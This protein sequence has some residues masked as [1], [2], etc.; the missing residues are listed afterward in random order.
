MSECDFNAHPAEPVGLSKPEFEGPP[1]RDQAPQ[2]RKAAALWDDSVL[3]GRVHLAN[4]SSWPAG[5]TWIVAEPL[6][7][8]A[9]RTECLEAAVENIGPPSAKADA[10]GADE[11]RSAGVGDGASPAPADPRIA[12]AKSRSLPPRR[13]AAGWTEPDH[14]QRANGCR[15]G[16]RARRRTGRWRRRGR[17]GRRGPPP[18]RLQVG[19]SAKVAPISSGSANPL[20]GRHRSSRGA[21]QVGDLPHYF[22]G[23]DDQLR[24]ARALS[25]TVALAWA[26]NAAQPIRARRSRRKRPTA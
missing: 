19:L 12:H 18:P 17:A 22:I 26:A 16:R 1:S 7:R 21:E 13:P 15:A 2:A 20:R 11:W 24:R 14:A 5:R 10:Q 3:I 25:S 4:V 6:P 9:A 8:A 23:C